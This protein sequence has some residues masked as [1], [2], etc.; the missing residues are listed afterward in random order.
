MITL[1]RHVH[2]LVWIASACTC[3]LL[4]LLGALSYQVIDREQPPG[5]S[6]FMQVQQVGTS[7]AKA[8]S[9]LEEAAHTQNINL[10]RVGANPAGPSAAPWYFAFVGDR[11]LFDATIPDGE[12]PAFSPAST[13]EV[14]EGAELMSLNQPIRGTYAVQGQATDLAG[15]GVTLGDAGLTV[16]TQKVDAS[17]SYL[18]GLLLS[19]SWPILLAS[20]IALGLVI[21]YWVAFS[22]KAT[23][24]QEFHGYRRRRLIRNQ[25]SGLIVVYATAAAAS[26]GVGSA[27]LGFYNGWN[28][29][30]QFIWWACVPMLIVGAIA[31]GVSLIASTAALR[32]PGYNAVKGARP[33][34]LLA[35]SAIL[36]QLLMIVLVYASLAQATGGIATITADSRTF[37]SWASEENSLT[38]QINPNAFEDPASK[39]FEPDVAAAYRSFGNIFTALESEGSA[40]LSFHQGD[41]H[42]DTTGAPLSSYDPLGGNSLVVNNNY[43]DRHEILNEDG[44]S[45]KDLPPA[46]RTV[47]LLIPESMSSY[48]DQLTQRWAASTVAEYDPI[49]GTEPE[50][51]LQIIS[52]IVKSGQAVFNYGDTWRME[53]WTQQDPVIAVVSSQTDYFS[54]Y[55]LLG[56]AANDGNVIFADGEKFQALADE[57]GLTSRFSSISSPATHAAQELRDR[58]TELRVA[59]GNA[60]LGSLTLI[61]TVLLLAAIY[62]NATRYSSFLKRTQ[63]WRGLRIHWIFL[64]SITVISA[65]AV[66]AATILLRPAAYTNDRTGIAV[67][68]IMALLIG[69][70]V[71][72]ATASFDR[73]ARADLIK[74]R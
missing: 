2:P 5:T 35:A 3:G 66:T 7:E 52:H 71:F 50:E 39:S 17:R 72:F 54:D 4:F 37:D 28:Q 33:M 38:V 18:T 43:L 41:K 60:L 34:R 73:R 49:D 65:A 19:S 9:A 67:A 29:Y 42:T 40:V 36:S 23:A 44:T 59:L 32:L 16:T 21:I 51:P 12:Y 14:F 26:V 20:V 70:V 58:N 46:A 6:A 8:I 55:I 74:Q 61:V 13:P 30:S 57:A 1:A 24:L 31:L 25:A 27:V 11:G 69:L 68:V 45:V 48:T 10:L 56:V 15:L 64:V 47:H 62:A 53:H 63:G 22:R